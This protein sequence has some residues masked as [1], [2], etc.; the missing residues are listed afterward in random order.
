LHAYNQAADNILGQGW[1][2]FVRAYAQIFYKILWR[3]NG[4][5]KEQNRVLFKEQNKVLEY[6]IIIINY[7]III[8]NYF[9]III[10]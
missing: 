3:A 2:N 9:T 1:Q 8:I 4:N 10:A 6:S 7:S 5:F